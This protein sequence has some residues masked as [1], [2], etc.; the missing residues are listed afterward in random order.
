MEIRPQHQS[1]SR[2]LRGANK[3]KSWQLQVRNTETLKADLDLHS[4]SVSTMINLH[5]QGE[6]AANFQNMKQEEEKAVHFL[7]TIPI[8][9]RHL[10]SIELET[11]L[12]VGLD[13]RP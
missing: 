4:P 6:S 3:T 12:G 8:C 9:L 11:D 7:D 5:Y 1:R 13:L 10:M 2:V